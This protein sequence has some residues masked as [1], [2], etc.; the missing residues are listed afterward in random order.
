MPLFLRTIAGP[1]SLHAVGELGSSL[2]GQPNK[3]PLLSIALARL[4][5]HA[6]ISDSISG[7]RRHL[8]SLFVVSIVGH[9]A[10]AFL[11]CSLNST[12]LLIAG[13]VNSDVGRMVERG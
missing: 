6:G 1:S 9:A 5:K 11:N 13:P 8:C 2:F 12:L 3:Q 7:L 4:I 10:S